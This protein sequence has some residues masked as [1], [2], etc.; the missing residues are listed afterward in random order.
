M[1]ST[2]IDRR[3]FLALAG[4]A[5]FP[6]SGAAAADEALFLG[7]RLNGGRYEAAVMDE[8]GRDRLVL[9]LEGRGHSF[10]IDAP[11]RRAVAFARSPGRF[12]VAFDVDGKTEPVAIAA[13]PDRHFFGHGVFT[14]DGKLM[15]ATENDFEGGRGVMGVYDATDAFRRVG[16]FPTDGIG[17][18]EAVLLTDGKT[19]CVANGGILTHPDYGGTKLNLATMAPSLSYID[20]A[21][22]DMIESASLAAELHQLSIRH[23]AIDRAGNIWFGC[24][25]EG[26]PT[27]MPPLV[28]RH[29]RGREIELFPG[30]TDILQGLRNYIGSVAID[31]SGGMLATSSPHG[32]LIAFWDTETG[33]CLG[34]QPLADGCGVAPAASMEVLATSGRGAIITAGP[35]AA[36]SIRAEA[37]GQPAWDNHL[38]RV[39]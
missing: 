27:D 36:Q 15:L 33:R 7:A 6:L 8:R 12:A 18:H 34:Q 29:Q 17:P 22:G 9:P 1:R 19:L 14:L 35:A 4:G 16:E 31:P 20:I 10:A 2:A 38:R 39:W 11:R 30:P 32:G 37:T 24:Q 13:A 23:M 25:Y 28:G 5:L 26:P 21:T 3:T